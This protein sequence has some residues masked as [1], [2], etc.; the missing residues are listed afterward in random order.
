MIYGCGTEKRGRPLKSDIAWKMLNIIIQLHDSQVRRS[1]LRIIINRFRN[2]L[3]LDHR[4]VCVCARSIRKSNKSCLMKILLNRVD[5]D[6][7]HPNRAELNR[8]L[9]R[10]C[11]SIIGTGLWLMFVV[12]LQMSKEMEWTKAPKGEK[13]CS[14][15]E[16]Q[17][18]SMHIKMRSRVIC[19]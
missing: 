16:S 17:T 18:D 19:H 3:K 14:R 13:K 5:F 8:V 1:R 4:F 6:L 12:A 15:K 10:L 2:K 11:I 7:T 9:Y